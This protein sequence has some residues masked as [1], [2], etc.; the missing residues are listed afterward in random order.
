MVKR[1]GRLYTQLHSVYP[2]DTYG[3]PFWWCRGHADIYISV[4]HLMHWLRHGLYRTLEGPY[5][6]E[7]LHLANIDYQVK[8]LDLYE[9]HGCVAAFNEDCMIS[10]SDGFMIEIKLPYERK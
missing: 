10:D 8:H 3:D 5:F 7:K 9:A 4:Y 2:A 6:A 1:F